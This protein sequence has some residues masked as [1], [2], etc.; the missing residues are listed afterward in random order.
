MNTTLKEYLSDLRGMYSHGY[1]YMYINGDFDS[2]LRKLS[3]RDLGTFFHEYVH[4]IQNISTLWGIKTGI[5]TN[6][7]MCDLFTATQN[8]S[9]IHIPFASTIM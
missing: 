8:A 2:Q 4:F 3:V 6:N 7:L 9:E 5:M 1:F